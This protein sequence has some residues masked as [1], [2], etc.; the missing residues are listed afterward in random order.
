MVFF[1][2]ETTG[3]DFNNSRIIEIGYVVIEKVDGKFKRTKEVDEF[4]KQPFVL[5]EIMT[6]RTN[7]YGKLESI[8][9]LTG[10]STEQMQSGITEDDL[11]DLLLM[12]FFTPD[13]LV[14]AYNS[15]FDLN[16][17]KNLLDRK[18][19]NGSEYIKSV[20]HLDLLTVYKDYNAYSRELDPSGKPLGHRLDAAVKRYKVSHINTHR[21]IDDVLATVEVYYSMMREEEVKYFQYYNTFGFNPKFENELEKLDGIEY[22]PQPY[23][24]KKVVLYEHLRRYRERMRLA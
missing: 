7:E 19:Y 12:D 10:I 1:D 16:M 13:T 22:L 24:R 9:D 3:I 17:V 11:V 21:A 15:N 6:S 20:D 2:T 8:A 5:E 14:I 4:I 18:G 23:N